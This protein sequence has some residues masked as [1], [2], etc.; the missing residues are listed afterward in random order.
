MGKV[1]RA[2]RLSLGAERIAKQDQDQAENHQHPRPDKT[3]FLLAFRH[4]GLDQAA[5]G[6]KSQSIQSKNTV[7]YIIDC[8]GIICDSVC[9]K[10][11]GIFM[12]KD[13]E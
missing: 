11:M 12:E 4:A 6:G 3:F 7:C 5:P 8:I 2:A 1:R 9:Y 10:I 13:H